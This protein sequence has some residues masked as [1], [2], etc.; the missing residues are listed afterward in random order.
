MLKENPMTYDSQLVRRVAKYVKSQL[1]KE[2]TGHDWY[3]AGRVIKNARILQREEG[4]DLMLIELSALLHD[5]GDYKKYDFNETKGNF[6]LD[7]MMD[8]LEINRHLQEDIMS[9]VIKSQYKGNETKTPNSIEGRIIQD[10]DWLETLGAIGIAR[11][12][13]TGGQARRMLYD[14]T[15]KPRANL[16]KLDHQRKKTSGTSINYFF[17]KSLKLPNMM[18]TPTGKK[19]ARHRVKFLKFY[20]K[21]FLSEWDGER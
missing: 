7:A 18:N 6:A 1:C 14:P 20:I 13:A 10:A 2:H 9:I 16:S 17:E 8:I 5:L 15:I 11:A 3:H 21:Q 4:G 19:I 12:F